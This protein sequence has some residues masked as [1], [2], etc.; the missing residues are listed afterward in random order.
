MK[1]ITAILLV[2]LFTS[3]AASA[4]E[5]NAIFNG[6]VTATCA[7]TIGLPGV[8]DVNAGSTVLSSQQG[9]G[10]AATVAILATGDIFSVSTDAP[11]AFTVAPTGGSDNV[12]FATTYSGTGGTTIAETNGT[13]STSLNTGLT[14]VSVNM[15]ATKTSGAFNAG[16]YTGLVTVRCE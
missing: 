7:V 14:N 8:L 6:L 3:N 2:T 10:S 16:N 15:S 12:T 13:T 9:I 4:A 5:G 1:R 11:S